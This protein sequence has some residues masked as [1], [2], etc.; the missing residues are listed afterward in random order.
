RDRRPQ[1]RRSDRSARPQDTADRTGGPAQPVLMRRVDLLPG[2]DLHGFRRAVRV[3]IAEAAQPEAVVWTSG[4]PVLF[5]AGNFGEAPPVQLP[6]RLADL[7]Q[8]VVQHRDPERYAL[9]YGLVW[10]SLR[11]NRDLIEVASDPVVHR[12]ELMR[13][14][15]RRDIHKMHAFL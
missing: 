10:R 13:K 8:E 7:I 11:D 15:V 4:E 2:A 12:L 1:P 3:L 6:R 5:G 9:L 14:A